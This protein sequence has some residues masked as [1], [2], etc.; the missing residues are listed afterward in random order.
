MGSQEKKRDNWMEKQKSKCGAQNAGNG[1]SEFQISIFS[2]DMPPD[3]PR[4][5]GPTTPCSYS[6]LFFPI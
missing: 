3:P 1:I 4:L 5:R 2:G 6:R